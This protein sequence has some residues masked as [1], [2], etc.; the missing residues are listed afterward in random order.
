M[1][2]IA[3]DLTLRIIRKV[4]DTVKLCR[5]NHESLQSA[6]AYSA[7]IQIMLEDMQSKL[8]NKTMSTNP[9]LAACIE[10]VSAALEELSR[11]VEHVAGMGKMAL[12]FRSDWIRGK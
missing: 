2:E 9:A 1:A 5:S 12:G 8:V 6:A 4:V 11:L 10:G 7:K 3:I